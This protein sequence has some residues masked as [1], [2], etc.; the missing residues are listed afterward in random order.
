MDDDVLAAEPARSAG[1]SN[2][3]SLQPQPGRV[4]YSESSSSTAAAAGANYSNTPVTEVRDTVCVLNVDG[5]P[6][7]SQSFQQPIAS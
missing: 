3:S 7:V 2:V 5:T 6:F 4:Q 1:G